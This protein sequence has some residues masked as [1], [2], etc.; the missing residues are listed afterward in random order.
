[1]GIKIIL[2]P[3]ASGKTAACIERIKTVQQGNP[4]A[5]AWVIVPNAQ[6]AAYFKS[7]LATAGGAMGVKVS[8]FRT[9]YQEVLEESDKFVPVITPA[10][11]N[12][13]IQETVDDV[14][15][16]GK[17]SHYASIKGKLGFLSMLQDAFAELR[18]A[19]VKPANFLEYTRETSLAHH[20]LAILY[21]HFLTRLESIN[22]I[23]AEGQ[24]WLA[25]EALETKP[26]LLSKL[27]LVIADGFSSFTASQIQFFKQINE[28]TDEVFITLTGQEELSRQVDARTLDVV[29]KL[30]EVFPFE[31]VELKAASHLPLE[32]QHLQENI[33]EPSSTEKLTT[34]QAIL[35]E[36]R[37]QSDEV[38]GALRWI[39]QLHVRE[40]IPLKNCA[41]YTANIESY[42]PL[43]RSVAS[44]FGMNI[45]FSQ[46]DTLSESPLVLA[47]VSFLDLPLKNYPTRVLLNVLRSP[48]FDFGLNPGDVESLEIISQQ[49]IIVEGKQQWDETWQIFQ[50]SGD[51]D[52]YEDEDRRQSRKL[53]GIDVALMRQHLERFWDLF[54][55]MDEKRSQTDWVRWLEN[56]LENCAFYERI[57]SAR[58]R[59]ACDSLGE[60]LSAL[61]LSESIAGTKIVDY[62]QF[63]A[64]LYATLTDTQLE[65]QKEVLKNA[66]F[67]G[68]MVEARAARYDAV[69]LLGLSEGQFPVV[70]N[71]DPL[72]DE[73]L[74][75]ELGLEPRLGRNQAS[76]FYQAFTRADKHLLITRP[77]LTEKG[78]KWE[79]SIYWEESKKLFD[80][81]VVHRQ[82]SSQTMSQSKAASVQE[83]LFLAVQQQ[84]LQYSEDA[85]LAQ[86]WKYLYHAQGILDARRAKRAQ[87]KFEGDL[88]LIENQISSLFSSDYIW[89]AS[90]LE[91]YAAC[92]FWFYI[93]VVL[94]L[95]PKELP[96]LGLDAAQLGSINHKVLEDVYLKAQKEGTSPLALLDEIANEVFANA[97]RKFGFRPSALWE[98]EKDEILETLR[99][100]LEALEEQKG[101]WEPFAFENKFGIGDTKPL[102]LELGDG[103]VKIRGLIDRLDRN[104]DG[105]LR[106]IDYKTSSTHFYEADLSNGTRLQLPIYA[107]A[108]QEALQLGEVSEGFYWGI[109][110]AEPSSIKLSKYKYNDLKGPQ[111]AYQ[112]A[113]D[114]IKATL[115]SIRLGQFS[116]RAPKG[117]CP[118]YCP[119]IA[120]CWKYKARF[121]ND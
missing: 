11:S 94:K 40:Q 12:R 19:M 73:T 82:E 37:S 20:E 72:L 86:R 104:Q 28:H 107:L 21:D 100:T 8:N 76:T 6:K 63:L 113:L 68:K 27:S 109:N 24:A 60:A 4:L 78:E 69:V 41:I 7:R 30:K 118:E 119:A 87:G 46:T 81:N 99:K 38:S 22:W 80:G 115:K 10:L 29:N 39:K 71:P 47:L 25:I 117:S 35:L 33:L 70:E 32:I 89:S 56:T 92:P 77:Y 42:K 43:L 49:A 45:R 5:K 16:L 98:V 67:V 112:V 110:K 18:S 51:P 108:A 53:E 103:S 111:A 61:V 48:Y 44:E 36:A 3:P 13:L 91:T 59:E 31:I 121:R 101:E 96:E 97:P 65:E 14:Y 93:N 26:Q 15:A 17:L 52:A 85:E 116:P 88:S 62:A 54:V 79:P 84:N 106:V 64:D 9:F 23:D 57:S 34:E 55:K 58:D 74:R 105:Q 66:V 75:E 83:L 1:M 120:W 114:H 102:E 90:R 2:S 95:E 50:A